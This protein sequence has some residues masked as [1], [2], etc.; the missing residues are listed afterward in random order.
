[1][2]NSDSEDKTTVLNPESNDNE[3]EF[4]TIGDEFMEMFV[5]SVRV[6]NFKGLGDTELLLEPDVTFIVGR[7]NSGKSRLLRALAIAV[8]SVRS[9]P[10][11][12]TVD[13]EGDTW[14]EITIAPRNKDSSQT[15]APRIA[16]RLSRFIQL[17]NRAPDIERICFRTTIKRSFEGYGVRVNDD[18]QAMTFDLPSRSWTDV[19]ID[20]LRLADRQMLSGVLVNTKRDLVEDLTQRNSA[21]R[22]LL[23]DLEIDASVRGDLEKKLMELSEQ[24]VSSSQ[25]L[26]SVQESLGELTS[27]IGS[28]GEPGVRALPGR[29]EDLWQAVS[30]DLDTGSGGL[31]ARFHGAGARSLASLQIQRLLYHKLLGKDIGTFTPWPL[32]MIEE[33][34]VH[35]HPQAQAELPEL[36]SSIPGQKIIS[37]H[38]PHLVTFIEPR[39]IRVLRNG[40]DGLRITDFAEDNSGSPGMIRVRRPDRHFEEMEKLK[41]LV[42]RPFGELIFADMIVMGDGA[43][44]R[45]FLP[46]VI[47]DALGPIAH[48]V[49]V[50]NPE[51][52]SKNAVTN[53]IHKFSQ[54]NGI[55]WLAFCDGDEQGLIA[56]SQLVDLAEGDQTRVIGI[57]SPSNPFDDVAFETMLVAFDEEL[58]VDA[59]REIGFVGGP[60]DVFNFMKS[61]K[62]SMGRILAI[63]FLE[64]YPWDEPSG[65]HGSSWPP[66]LRDLINQIDADLTRAG[67]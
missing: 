20:H 30:I 14:I 64:K 49:T 43:T 45:A 33:P 38:S 10:D 47:K 65:A 48:G 53:A 26:A 28:L 22:R 4:K 17:V 52:L 36:F 46:L 67:S 12:I 13:S 55:T 63:K 42:E 39:S 54:L 57:K 34:E 44:E 9:E 59:C 62:G 21:I 29:L 23:S 60:P 37:S 2:L 15:F 50:V 56:Q 6:K 31:P 35:L 61:K 19:P 16:A 3:G 24:I 32:T 11:D 41:R 1:M 58:C 8:N 25:S 7:N 66:C 40:L 5:E 27:L 18:H 51:G